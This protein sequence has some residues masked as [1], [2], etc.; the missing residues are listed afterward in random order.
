[1]THGAAPVAEGTRDDGARAWPVPVTFRPQALL[2]TVLGRHVLDHGSLMVGAGTFIAVLGLLG[3]S[4]Q[5]ARSTLTRM[6]RRGLLDRQQHGRRAYFTLSDRTTALL[7][8]G[9]ERIF[10]PAPVRQRWD[11]EPPDWPALEAAR[12]FH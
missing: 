6:V 7:V 3:V 8:E 12:R 9:G 10:A 4:E 11:G 1:V 5:A 2:L